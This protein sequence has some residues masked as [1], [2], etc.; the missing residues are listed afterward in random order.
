MNRAIEELRVALQAEPD[1]FN[2]YR[3]LSQAYGQT[4]DIANAELAMAEGNFRAGNRREAQG[5]CSAR[6]AETAQ[7]LARRDPGK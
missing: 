1:N 5:I 3:H 7:G 4:G 2:A 6:A